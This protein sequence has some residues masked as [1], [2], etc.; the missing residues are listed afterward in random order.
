LFLLLELIVVSI[1]AGRAV[2][3]FGTVRTMKSPVIPSPAI[4]VLPVLVAIAV[5]ESPCIVLLNSLTPPSL[6]PVVLIGSEQAGR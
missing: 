5:E 1:V 3:V 4:A 6:T 2:M